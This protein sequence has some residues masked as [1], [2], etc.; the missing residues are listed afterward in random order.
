MPMGGVSTDEPVLLGLPRRAGP[1][2]ELEIVSPMWV[3]SFR[4][5][6]APGSHYSTVCDPN[7]RGK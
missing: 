3:P 1:L 7:L 5:L 6:V 2:L 4:Q